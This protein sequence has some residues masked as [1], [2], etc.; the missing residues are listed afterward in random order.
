MT[1]D[2]YDIDNNSEYDEL[3]NTKPVSDTDFLEDEIDYM[4]INLKIEMKE[5][6]EH[7]KIPL[8]QYF[9]SEVWK[10][11]LSKCLK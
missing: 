10:N 4:I 2:E 1:I 8:L 6:I 5:Y 7:E 11:C 9:D 3:D